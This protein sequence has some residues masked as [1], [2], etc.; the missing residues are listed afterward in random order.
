MFISNIFRI[1]KGGVTGRYQNGWIRVE[2]RPIE[3]RNGLIHPLSQFLLLIPK[4]APYSK[5]STF[6]RL[7]ITFF[8]FKDKLLPFVDTKLHYN[9]EGYEIISDTI[10]KIISK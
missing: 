9:I 8:P 7:L 6:E 4:L 1:E 10:H 3:A 5:F 2:L